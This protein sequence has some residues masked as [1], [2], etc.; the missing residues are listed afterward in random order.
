MEEPKNI[1]EQLELC[2]ATLQNI[3]SNLNNTT[4]ATSQSSV[5]TTPIVNTTSTV[6]SNS[7]S[8]NI[9][10]GRSSSIRKFS[11]AI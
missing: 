2:F 6:S 4:A 8:S 3:A 5:A 9:S 7:T 11:V 10:Q 1:R